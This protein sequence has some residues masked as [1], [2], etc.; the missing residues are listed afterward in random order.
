MPMIALSVLKDEYER[1]E[2][3]IE[4]LGRQLEQYPKG[5]LYCYGG[6]YYLKYTENNVSYSEYVADEDVADLKTRLE[7][8]DR[9][10]ESVQIMKDD[11][12]ILQA[13]IS[14]Q[15]N[16]KRLSDHSGLRASI[17]RN[18]KSSR[19][20]LAYAQKQ[21]ND[22]PLGNLYSHEGYLYYRVSAKAEG[23]SGKRLI[24]LGRQE[25]DKARTFYRKYLENQSWHQ[26]IR[27]YK[28]DIRV[29]EE[30]L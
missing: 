22:I 29:F 11:L 4:A 7:K 15:K 12:A 1:Q 6:H 14:N 5:R 21:L 3:M 27:D 28:Q 16:R 26:K 19:E 10:K 30:L 23:Y 8:R 17:L 20:Y 13:V 18:L 9:L 25:S 24:Y 2:R